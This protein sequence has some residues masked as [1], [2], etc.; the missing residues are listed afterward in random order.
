MNKNMLHLEILIKIQQVS[1]EGF[2]AFEPVA[3]RRPPE[4]CFLFHQITGCVPRQSRLQQIE[5][6][7]GV[8]VFLQIVKI[9]AHISSLKPVKEK[10][11]IG[12]NHTSSH[13]KPKNTS[14]QCT[15]NLV[16]LKPKFTA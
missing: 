7:T 4:L 10:N 8:H 1:K 16:F 14:S 2:G 11:N 5:T 13:F 12:Y 15:N 9:L 3:A 6:D